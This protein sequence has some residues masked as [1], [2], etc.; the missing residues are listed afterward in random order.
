MRAPLFL[1]TTIAVALAAVSACFDWDGLLGRC[2]DAGNCLPP[3]G[4]DSGDGGDGGQDGGP[5]GGGSDGGDGGLSSRGQPCSVP[6]QCTTRACTGGL[7]VCAF[8]GGCRDTNDCCLG[9]LCNAIPPALG[10]C[11]SDT[12]IPLCG[13]QLS[14]CT[15]PTQC[16]SNAC[17][18]TMCGCSPA[19][20]RC[21]NLTDCCNGATCSDGKYC[22]WPGSAT[23]CTSDD[24][25]CSR[26]CSSGACL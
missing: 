17:N 6:S 3:N 22:C 16:C 23:G 14:G 15:L 18:G 20:I 10:T 13:G 25:C 19:G 5:D 1:L 24:Q 8:D 26:V 7:C 11:T 4:S 21:N 2:Q 9:Q 12:A